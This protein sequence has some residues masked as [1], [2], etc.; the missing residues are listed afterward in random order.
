VPDA[1]TRSLHLRRRSDGGVVRIAHTGMMAGARLP[2]LARFLVHLFGDVPNAAAPTA[3]LF[4]PEPEHPASA[5]RWRP[6]LSIGRVT[7]SRA[8]WTVRAGTVPARAKG[9]DDAGYLL[10]LAAWFA[11]HGIPARCYVTAGAPAPAPAPVKP[12]Y[13]DLANLLLVRLFERLLRD[14]EAVL[15]VREALPQLTDAPEIGAQ[16]RHVT[17]YV[18]EIGAA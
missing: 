2:R 12:V 17:E 8:S 18:V 5:V 4:D 14:P 15:T 7:V 10:T 6:R 11:E 13:L 16:G 9:T 1:A 3:Q